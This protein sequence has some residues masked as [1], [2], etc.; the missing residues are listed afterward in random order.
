[1]ALLV[2]AAVGGWTVS[3]ESGHLTLPV[4]S[5]PVKP[6]WTTKNR[7]AKSLRLPAS[8]RWRLTRDFVPLYIQH[9]PFG[10]EPDKF[11]PSLLQPARFENVPAPAVRRKS[12]TECLSG[13]R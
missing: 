2:R 12:I 9:M 7:P 6:T 11:D 13:L 3:R 5:G 8:G 10:Q 4:A 1:M